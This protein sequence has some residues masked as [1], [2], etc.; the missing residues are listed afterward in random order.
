MLR[1]LEQA[2]GVHFGQ[3]A[4]DLVD[5]AARTEIA[6]RAGQD[7]AL[8]RSRVAVERAERVAQLGIAVEGQ[9]IL[10]LGPV[11]RDRRDAVREVPP[12][13]RPARTSRGRAS[14]A[15][16]RRRWSRA[17]P[18]MSRLCGRQRVRIIVRDAV[19]IDQPAARIHVGDRARA[20]AP[21]SRPVIC[22]HARDRLVGHR[23]VDIARA[24]GV[25]GQFGLGDIRR[26]GCAS[27][28]AARASTRA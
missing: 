24:D 4:D 23:R 12:E 19:R 1:E 2:G 10:A 15:G 14:R 16:A 25:D 20:T 11:E 22:G 27:G 17:A 7:D 18:L 3:R 13:M 9:R 8:A 6:A 21:R 26:P 28:R 5:V